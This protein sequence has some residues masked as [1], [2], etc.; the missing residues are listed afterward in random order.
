[1]T[2]AYRMVARAE[3]ADRAR[4]QTLQAATKLFTEKPF[5]LVSLADVAREAGVGL[6]TV[7]RQFETKDRLFAEAVAAAQEALEAE[8]DSTPEN[9]PA[10]AVRSAIE[11]YERFGDAIV[12]LIAQEERVPAI[13]KVTDHGRD[14]HSRWVHRVF[15]KALGRLQGSAKKRR[16]A[17][18][19]AAT[20]VL[21]WKLLRRDLGLSRS[22]T[23][24]A[25]TEVVEALC[26]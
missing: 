2:R 26:R 16:F 21:F 3:S 17:Q 11:N 15:T 6:A 1:M 14:E 24:T 13:R 8:A 10:Q 4:R 25:M 23:E 5:D 18:L 22:E 19:M 7:V 20:D 9:D 12:R